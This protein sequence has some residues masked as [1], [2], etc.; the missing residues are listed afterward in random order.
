MHEFSIAWEPFEETLYLFFSSLVIAC[1]LVYI[2]KENPEAQTN[3]GILTEEQ[4]SMYECGFEPFHEPH[5]LYFIPYF[6]IAILFL[7]FDLELVYLFPW[8]LYSDFSTARNCFVILNFFL[9]IV[10]G[11]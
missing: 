3:F 6:S 11:L 10:L 8:I 7:I 2:S 5:E 9:F 4:A 1:T